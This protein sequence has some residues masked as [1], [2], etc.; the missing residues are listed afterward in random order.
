MSGSLW[1][2]SQDYWYVYTPDGDFYAESTAL[3]KTIVAV[4]PGAPLPGEV[5]R[6]NV[7]KLDGPVTNDEMVDLIKSARNAAMLRPRGATNRA[8]GARRSLRSYCG[9]WR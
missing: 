2:L 8:T 9:R 1:P 4:F 7:V 5:S 6:L 3:W